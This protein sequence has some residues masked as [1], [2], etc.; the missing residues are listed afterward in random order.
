[1]FHLEVESGTSYQNIV[2]DTVWA[3]F[4]C[5]PDWQTYLRNVTSWNG[6]P[7]VMW[8]EPVELDLRLRSHWNLLNSADSDAM[9]KSEH[10]QAIFAWHVKTEYVTTELQAYALTS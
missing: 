7:F 10:W 6:K 9:D 5:C 8:A 3:V 1:M 4:H 2:M